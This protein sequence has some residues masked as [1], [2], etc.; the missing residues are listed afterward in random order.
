MSVP[1]P[2]FKAQMRTLKYYSEITQFEVKDDQLTLLFPG[3]VNFA[4]IRTEVTLVNRYACVPTNKYLKCCFLL[5]HV[6]EMKLSHSDCSMDFCLAG[7]LSNLT[8]VGNVLGMR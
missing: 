8:A 1:S 2:I 5:T 7:I 4:W 6:S 3:L